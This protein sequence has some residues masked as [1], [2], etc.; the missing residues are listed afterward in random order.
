MSATSNGICL[1]GSKNAETFFGLPGEYME[2]AA[3]LWKAKIH[4]ED[5]GRYLK[6]IADVFSRRQDAPQL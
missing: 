3:E 6:D 1:T 4:P 5:R 2:N